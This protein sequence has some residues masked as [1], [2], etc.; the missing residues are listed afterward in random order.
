MEPVHQ[1]TAS[2]LP[3][4][5]CSSGCIPS[6]GPLLFDS[7][8]ERHNASRLHGETY[9]RAFDGSCG[10]ISARRWDPSS[11]YSNVL[12]EY[13]NMRVTLETSTRHPNQSL[14]IPQR[15]RHPL[16]AEPEG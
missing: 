4:L 14:D 15:E 12:K 8:A 2:H 11:F 16:L 9:W 3:V 7:L 1:F 5:S 6:A 13:F 10:R